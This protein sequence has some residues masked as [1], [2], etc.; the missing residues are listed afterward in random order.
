MDSLETTKIIRGLGDC[1]DE[2]RLK[3]LGYLVG[4]KE[5]WGGI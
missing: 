3:V 2:E 4:R 1:I 5:D